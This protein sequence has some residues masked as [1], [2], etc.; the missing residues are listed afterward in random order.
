LLAPFSS[1]R[2]ETVPDN[3]SLLDLPNP[4][5]YAFVLLKIEALNCHRKRNVE[6]TMK[7]KAVPV[8][9]RRKSVRRDEDIWKMRHT[10]AVETL[11]SDLAFEV[12]N[13]L[14]AVPALTEGLKE[15]IGNIEKA[16]TRERQEFRDRWSNGLAF[17]SERA[18]RLIDRTKQVRL[19]TKASQCPLKTLV[20]GVLENWR[21]IAEKKGVSVEC[22]GLDSL[23]IVRAYE[24]RLQT[25]F[26]YIIS[27]AI[28]VT[29]PGSSV[30]VSGQL[31]QAQGTAI[32]E[33]KDAGPSVPLNVRDAFNGGDE[34]DIGK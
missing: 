7:V 20:E 28:H 33:V 22:Q 2:H 25:L 14:I 4:S 19:Q 18:K 21:S 24:G 5:A 12:R 8:P 6:P 1:S 15:E 26:F 11:L 27:R 3:C 30:T 23:P 31:D 9:N 17:L 10:D 16:S 13:I 34:L 32:I 29:Q